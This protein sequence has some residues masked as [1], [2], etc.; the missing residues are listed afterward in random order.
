[1][2][3]LHWEADYTHDSLHLEPSLQARCAVP[4][5]RGRAICGIPGHR[6]LSLGS[7]FLK[8]Y[9][10]LT[11]TTVASYALQLNARFFSN[12]AALRKDVAKGAGG[13]QS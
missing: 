5:H 11:L 10:N 2:F 6:N 7:D 8:Q 13:G 4:R 3:T 1:M 9:R 12:S